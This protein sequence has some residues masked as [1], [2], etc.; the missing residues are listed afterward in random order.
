M[1][2][3]GKFKAIIDFEEACVYYR[4]FDLGMAIVGLCAQGNEI[5]IGKTKALLGGYQDQTR[6]KR[7]E[8]KYLQLFIE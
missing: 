5:K 8:R 3:K 2:D 6:L 7:Q 1:F 4:I